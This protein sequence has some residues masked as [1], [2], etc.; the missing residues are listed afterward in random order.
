MWPHALGKTGGPPCPRSWSS[1]ALPMLHSMMP[2]KAGPE[3]GPTRSSAAER[4]P[5]YD[6]TVSHEHGK[7]GEVAA[8][9]CG[10]RLVGL[11]QAAALGRPVAQHGALRVVPK[12]AV[13]IEVVLG[14]LCGGGREVR[15]GEPPPALTPSYRD[16]NK[17]GEMLGA[18]GGSLISL[19]TNDLSS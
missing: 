17:H 12:G 18:P 1:L 14:L 7:V 9:T 5:A 13:S 8:G 3:S 11:H 6:L 15:S 2:C 10:V 4:Q 19:G 16:S